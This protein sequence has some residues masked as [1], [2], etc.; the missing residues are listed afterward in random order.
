MYDSFMSENA[1]WKKLR[2]KLTRQG[3]DVVYSRSGHWKV[4]RGR[5]QI[6]VLCGTPGRGRAWANQLAQLK[7]AGVQL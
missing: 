4:C 1:D 6:G 3:F 7:R 5:Q 2:Q